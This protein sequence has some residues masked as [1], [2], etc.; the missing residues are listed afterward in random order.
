MIVCGIGVVI[1][2]KHLDVHWVWLA[3]MFVLLAALMLMAH[4]RHD[5]VCN[6]LLYQH[7]GESRYPESFF[8]GDLKHYL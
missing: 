4:Q 7:N 5:S 6:L 1:S 3:F 8:S 2:P